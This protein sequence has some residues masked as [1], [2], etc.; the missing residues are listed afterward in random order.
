CRLPACSTIEKVTQQYRS[1]QDIIDMFLREKCITDERHAEQPSQELYNA[2][3]EWVEEQM[4]EKPMAQRS[5]SQAL[6]E[7]GYAVQHT[8][9]GKVWHA[10]RL[11]TG[12]DPVPP[13][14]DDESNGATTTQAPTTTTHPAA[15]PTTHQA[16]PPATPPA[17]ETLNNADDA[18]RT[19]PEPRIKRGYIE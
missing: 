11:R 5:F 12:Y 8:R 10:L 7:L 13:D 14:D 15:R 1:D 3:S 17:T 19:H 4:G 9:T 18:S 6:Q 16:T 2:F